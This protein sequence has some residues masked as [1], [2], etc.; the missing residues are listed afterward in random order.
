MDFINSHQSL[1]VLHRFLE[2]RICK[3]DKVWLHIKSRM[4]IFSN[5]QDACNLLHTIMEKHEDYQ[6]QSLKK[7]KLLRT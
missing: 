5:W 1:V 6:Q 4:H 7:K 2:C 3:Y